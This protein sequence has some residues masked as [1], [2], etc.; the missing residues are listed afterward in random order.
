MQLRRHATETQLLAPMHRLLESDSKRDWHQLGMC[1][2]RW[3]VVIPGFNVKAVARIW[4]PGRESNPNV[5]A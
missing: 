5:S 3:R 1:A 4:D 2:L